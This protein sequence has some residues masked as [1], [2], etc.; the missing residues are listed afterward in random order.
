MIRRNA[1]FVLTLGA[2]LATGVHAHTGDPGEKYLNASS[3]PFGREKNETPEQ[4][5]QAARDLEMERHAATFTE[6]NKADLPS[7]ERQHKQLEQRYRI[8][9]L[10]M[11]R[12]QAK[13]DQK[14]RESAQLEKEIHVEKLKL[15]KLFRRN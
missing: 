9:V 15:M 10:R 5:E 13:D 8:A 12:D 4:V 6:T 7:L 2:L 1:F 3:W 14:K 11:A